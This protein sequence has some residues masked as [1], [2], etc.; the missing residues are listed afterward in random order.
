MVFIL[1]FASV[2]LP[3]DMQLNNKAKIE[4]IK[5]MLN[6]S[7]KVL[8]NNIDSENLKLIDVSL[9]STI[10]K[11]VEISVNKDKLLNDF[12]DTVYKNLNNTEIFE[13]IKN[14]IPVKVLV[15]YDRFFVAGRDNQW[16]APYFFT[17]SNNNKTY[18]L[19]N[20]NTQ[21]YYFEGGEEKT[22]TI[23]K[24]IVDRVIIERINSVVTSYTNANLMKE[25]DSPRYTDKKLYIEIQNP[26]EINIKNIAGETNQKK[27]NDFMNNRNRKSNF[28]ILNGITF[29]VVYLEEDYIGIRGSE[30]IYP[31]YNVVGYTLD[32]DRK[33]QAH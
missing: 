15:F 11:N 32:M 1:L 28:N 22:A 12:F 30:I 27:I 24:S 29:F 7:A 20:R 16:S 8:I 4:N 9:G 3:L 10:P 18:Y 21:A 23:N 19:N 33:T 13:S 26:S 17:Y 6:L 2:A 14:N 5:Q 25:K 31:N